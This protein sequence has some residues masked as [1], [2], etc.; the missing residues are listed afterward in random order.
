PSLAGLYGAPV[1]LQ[2]GGTV[3]ADEA[4]IR[5][6]IL[7][8]HAKI[9]AGFPPVMPTFKGLVSEDGILQIIAYLKALRKEERAAAER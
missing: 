8:P 7:E 3:K 4:Y 6:S 5:E 2:G 1:K 9:A